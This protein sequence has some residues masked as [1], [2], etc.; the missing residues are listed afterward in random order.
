M[1]LLWLDAEKYL[2]ISQQSV[3]QNKTQATFPLD[4][5]KRELITLN[6]KSSF[7]IN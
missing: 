3:F 2:S 7:P 5:N 1:K 6:L 4:L